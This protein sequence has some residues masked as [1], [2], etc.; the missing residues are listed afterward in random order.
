M[1]SDGPIFRARDVYESGKMPHERGRPVYRVY[2]STYDSTSCEYLSI[3]SNT[4]AFALDIK[5]T[6]LIR[7]IFLLLYFAPSLLWAGDNL[8]E[9]FRNPPEA[10]KPWCYWYWIS[11]NISKEG[12]SRDLEAMA[13]VGIVE[14]CIGNIFRDDVPAGEIKV[15][16]DEWWDLIEHAIREGDR[17]GVNI[18]MFNCPGW[19]Q[20]GGPWIE[21]NQA[22]RYLVS[23]ETRV[24]G[25]S[26]F[27][28]KLPAP[29]GSFQ[30][31]SVIAF[32]AP[33]ADKDSLRKHLP[34]V[35]CQLV[36]QTAVEG[37]ELAVDGQLET[38]LLLPEGDTPIQ[39]TIQT[40]E[41]LKVTYQ[42]TFAVSE[43]SEGGKYRLEL[44]DVGGM[45]TVR[46]NGQDL[47]TLWIAPWQVDVSD[48][49][50]V[51]ENALEIEVVVPWYNRLVGDWPL[52]PNERHS[53]LSMENDLAD[54]P[55]KPA[56]L[57]EEVTIRV[58]RSVEVK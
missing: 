47:E 2:L 31:V 35:S 9:G 53:Y 4:R 32:P 30:D 7:T 52:K 20:S 51:G 58:A 54:S 17:V 40:N 44:G 57:L 26:R 41:P 29:T 14:A 25:P 23:T 50:R 34:K 16:I 19:S 24:Q 28:Q 10:T 38:A 48:A 18:G 49:I 33:K 42:T 56:G 22:M 6:L 12:I 8:A 39:I 43:A 11:D 27:S 15:L 37:A 1:G 46:L 5:M 21:E 13:R 55:L 45:A 36:G 3:L